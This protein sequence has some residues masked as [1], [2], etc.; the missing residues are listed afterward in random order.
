M[1]DRTIDIVRHD[2]VKSI[3]ELADHLE[4]K[5]KAKHKSTFVE[6]RLGFIKRQ[7]N[8][9]CEIEDLPLEQ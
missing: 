6:A 9:L 2:L 1:T 7:Y 4:S 3:K 8:A 5:G